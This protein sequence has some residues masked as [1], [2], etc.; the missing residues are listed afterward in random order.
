[1]SLNIYDGINVSLCVECPNGSSIIKDSFYE[2]FVAVTFNWKGISVKI[3]LK[4]ALDSVGLVS[5]LF[6]VL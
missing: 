5:D 2:R 3:M 4:K 6:N 1:M